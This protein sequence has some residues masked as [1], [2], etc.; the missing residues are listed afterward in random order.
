MLRAIRVELRKMF[1]QRGTYAGFLVLAIMIGLI[2]WGMWR[3]SGCHFKLDRMNNEDF[4]VSGNAT[5]APF[6]MQFLLPATMEV[7]MPLLIA[8]IAG[9]LVAAEVRSGTI[10]TLL[11][12]PITRLQLLTGKMVAV[13]VYTLTLCVFVML[14]GGAMAYSIFGPGDLMSILAHG[15][16]IFSHQEALGRLALAYG[17]AFLGRLVI[18]LIALMFSCLFDNGLTAA[19]LTVASLIVFNALQQIPYFESWSPYFLT[20]LL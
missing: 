5:T 9:G 2:V 13:W 8:A 17:F 11:L 19:A 3:H 20:K 16:V 4:L 7:L 12:R 6:V 10:R 14:F 1:S 18:A 15:L